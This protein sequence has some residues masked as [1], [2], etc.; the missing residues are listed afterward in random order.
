MRAQMSVFLPFCQTAEAIGATASRLEKA[1]I[2]GEYFA[3]L[4][5]DDLRRAALYFGGTP[6]PLRENRV[7]NIGGAALS[8]VTREVSGAD[9]DWLAQRLVATGD[10]GETAFEAWENWADAPQS[11]TLTLAE[12]ENALARLS[13]TRGSKA[14]AEIVIEIL[15]R[16]TAL[17][18]QYWAKM[19][20][21]DLRIGLKESAVEDALARLFEVDLAKVQRAN[22][23]AGDLGEVAVLARHGRLD[24]AV[25]ELFHPLKFMLATPAKDND[26]IEKTMPTPFRVEDKFD[27]IRAQAHIAPHRAHDEAL[28]GENYGDV[29]VALFS[30]ALNE[31]TGAFPDLGAPL[32]A[33]LDNEAGLVLD[34]EIVPLGED[35]AIAAFQNLQTRLNRKKPSAEIIALAPLAFVAYDVLFAGNKELELPMQQRRAVLERLGF[36]GKRTRLAAS[37]LFENIADLDAEFDAARARGN[38]GLMIKDPTSDYKPGKR[39]RQWLKVKKATDTLDVV[40]TSVESG[41]GRRSKFYSDYTFAVRASADD[42]TLLNV[43]KAYS[44]LTDAEITELSEWFVAHTIQSFAHGRVRTVEPQIVLEITFDKVQ[45]SPRHKSGYALR[46][47]RILRRRDDKPVEEIDTLEAVKKLAG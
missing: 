35:G 17:E 13:G 40:V 38:E 33:L 26:D 21:G 39:G 45:P 29:R 8:S 1:K 37:T 9:A 11:A 47:P 43:G 18:A 7:V 25:F 46:F 36:D 19:L 4:P 31:I 15:K 16:A 3:Q 28:H 22:M 5:D 2:I 14:K 27:G 24:E 42:A 12:I 41:S 6:F 30:R 32:A 10:A 20:S 34:G 23:L 44:G